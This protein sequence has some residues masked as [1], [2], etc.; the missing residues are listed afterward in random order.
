MPATYTDVFN[1]ATQLRAV[2]MTNKAIHTIS[3]KSAEDGSIDGNGSKVNTVVPP[4]VTFKLRPKQVMQQPAIA[5]AS[6][7]SV[8]ANETTFDKQLMRAINA[9]VALFSSSVHRGTCLQTVYSFLV[10][11]P[12]ALVV[13]ERAFSAAGIFYYKAPYSFK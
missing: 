7:S 6:P 13:A 8:A 2:L 12:P 9:E 5:P 3:S 4:E 11:V 1:F 10:T